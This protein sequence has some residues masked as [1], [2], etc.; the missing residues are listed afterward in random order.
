MEILL[1]LIKK[2]LLHFLLKKLNLIL[3]KYKTKTTIFPKIQELDTKI[4]FLCLYKLKLIK[5]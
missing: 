2:K 4:I 3:S 5:I 1:I